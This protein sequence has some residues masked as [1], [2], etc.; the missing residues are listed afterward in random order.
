MDPKDPKT[1]GA[2]V[3]GLLALIGGAMGILHITTPECAQCEVDL[4]V[5]EERSSNRAE[6]IELHEVALEACKTALE[7][8]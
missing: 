6:R 8:Q 7:A 1:I 3:L 5:C 4:A 2:G